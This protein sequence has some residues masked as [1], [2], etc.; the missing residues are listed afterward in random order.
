VTP[1]VTGPPVPLVAIRREL[2]EGVLPWWQHHGVDAEHGGVFTVF[3]NTG[4]LTSTDKYTWSQ[5]RWAWLCARLAQ[6]ARAGV[7]DLDAETW[8]GY[9]LNTAGFVARHALLPGSV[10]A[11][12]TTAD[13]T[14]LP[15]G[16]NGELAVSVLT[17]L[18]AALGLSGAPRL[19]DQGDEQRARWLESAAQLLA[20]ATDRMAARTAPSEPYPV[21]AGFTDLA[22]VMLR[23][24]VGTELYAVDGRAETARYAV[25]AARDLVGGERAMWRPED[26]W[27]FRPDHPEDADT[28]LARHRTPGHLLETAWMLLDSADHVAAV[29]ELVPGWLPDLVHRAFALGWDDQR[30]GLFRYVDRAGGKPTG[31]LYGADRYEQLVFDTWDTKL[32]WVHVEAL[33]AAH[34]FDRTYPGRGFDDWARRLTDYTLRTFPDPAGQEWLQVRDRAGRPLDRVVALPV[35]DPFHIARALLLTTEIETDPESDGDSP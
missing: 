5:G 27:E 23:L 15:S 22:G 26:W 24:H 16:P 28:M 1:A 3:D 11:H 14:P 32:W 34:R 35:K 13:G 4:R 29:A 6:D 30:A 18:F 21:R 19:L 20:H 8:A 12:L 2:E 33:L 17:D 31:R 10:T 9:A 25:D 7:V